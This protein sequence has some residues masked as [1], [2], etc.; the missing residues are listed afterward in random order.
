[1]AAA[2]NES[3]QPRSAGTQLRLPAAVTITTSCGAFVIS[4]GGHVRRTSTDP[5]P[6]PQGASWWPSTG[7]WDKLVGGHLIVG[8]WQKRLWRSSGS[9]RVAY[10]VGAITVGPHALAFSY[11]NRTPH[12]YVAPLN[13]SERQLATGEYPVGWTRGGFYTRTLRGG[14]LL[15][16]SASGTH[17]V[18]LT[19]RVSTY[20]HDDA[21]SNLYFIAD[22]MLIRADGGAQR[23]I[24]TSPV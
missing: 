24:G 19:R 8:R 15:L 18:T 17:Q 22:G 5:S 13:G 1:V 3:C 16:R 20:A 11:G 10:Q 21:R 14:M 23:R 7:V 4:R 12:L 2:T 6:V 9:F